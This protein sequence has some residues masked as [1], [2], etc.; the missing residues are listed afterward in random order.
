MPTGIYDL[1]FPTTMKIPDTM[2]SSIFSKV[3]LEIYIKTQI[4]SGK[5]LNYCYFNHC[6]IAGIVSPTG[7]F[8]P[9]YEALLIVVGPVISK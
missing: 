8:G 7:P 2:R 6:T 9:P 3:R 1:Y 4:I 5:Q